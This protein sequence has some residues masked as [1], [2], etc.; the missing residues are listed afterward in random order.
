MGLADGAGTLN[1]TRGFG[2]GSW[3][4]L[5]RDVSPAAEIDSAL[6]FYGTFNIRLPIHKYG[7]LWYGMRKA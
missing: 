5:D 2:T 3:G 1:V 4:M 6:R 7:T